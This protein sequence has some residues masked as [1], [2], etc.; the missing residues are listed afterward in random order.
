MVYLKVTNARYH[1]SSKPKERPREQR[2][3]YLVN[4]EGVCKET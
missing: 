4:N 3:R 2:E 1:V